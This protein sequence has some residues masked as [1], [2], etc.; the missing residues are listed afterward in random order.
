MI[1]KNSITFI[2]PPQNFHTIFTNPQFPPN[3]NNF[4]RDA[5]VHY[6]NSSFVNLVTTPL[7]NTLETTVEVVVVQVLVVFEVTEIFLVVV[8]VEELVVVVVVVAV[9]AV[10]VVVVEEVE[11]VVVVVAVVVV[12]VVGVARE[13]VRIGGKWGKVGS[14][15]AR[16]ISSSCLDFW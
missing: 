14:T 16:V 6:S 5:P 12:V 11:V 9:V 10:V 1:K 4:S 13:R 7:D 2:P 15:R 8:V 3:F